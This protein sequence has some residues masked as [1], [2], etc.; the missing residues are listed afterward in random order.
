[1]GRT[2]VVTGLYMF[3]L[4]KTCAFVQCKVYIGLVCADDIWYTCTDRHTF[5]PPATLGGALT[6]ACPNNVCGT[7]YCVFTLMY[8][9]IVYTVTTCV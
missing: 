9:Y 6:Q 7:L 1:M 3:G 5:R 4:A 2:P 8:V